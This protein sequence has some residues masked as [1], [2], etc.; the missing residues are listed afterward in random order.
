MTRIVMGLV[1]CLSL[2][3]SG[4]LTAQDAELEGPLK[5]VDPTTAELSVMGMRVI[6]DGNT[7]IES[8]SATLTIDQLKDT[9]SL[10]GRTQQGFEGGTA[11]VTGTVDPMTGNVTAATVFVEPSENVILGVVTENNAGELKVNGVQIK[12]L[13]DPRIPLKAVQNEFGFEVKRESIPVA[14]PVAVEGYYDGTDFQTF[15]VEIDGPATLA[16]PDPQVSV[17]RAQTR[18][19]RADR[20]DDVTVRGAVTTAHVTPGTTRQTIG[21]Y[22]VDNGVEALIATV[23][24]RIVADT[25]GFAKWSF[26]GATDPSTHPVYGRAPR[27]IKAVNL[28]AGANLASDQIDA[29]VRE[30]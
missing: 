5:S 17:L 19:R 11:T 18:E 12:Y 25:P 1:F 7:R 22:R 29:E 3:R 20:G 6:V 13:N 16:N 8:P 10:P 2:I 15:L 14:T 9:A 30:E 21:I 27:I 4:V 28:S 24:A 26:N 23:Q